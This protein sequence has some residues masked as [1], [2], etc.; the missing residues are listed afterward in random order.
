MRHLPD[1]AVIIEV[2]CAFGVVWWCLCRAHYMSQATAFIDRL[3]LVLIGMGAAAHAL[4]PLPDF[5]VLTFSSLD[6]FKGSLLFPGLAIWL[7]APPLRRWL[8]QVEGRASARGH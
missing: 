5:G 8:A 6:H 7:M 4:S 1:L 2:L 3:G